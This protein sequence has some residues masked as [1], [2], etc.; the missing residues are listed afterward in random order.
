MLAGC[1]VL[2]GVPEITVG[3]L[4]ASLWGAVPPESACV[5]VCRQRGIVA[6]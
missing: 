6:G 2:E 1:V 5:G 4:G 3:R